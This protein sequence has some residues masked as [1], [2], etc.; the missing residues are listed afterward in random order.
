[1]NPA[2]RPRQILVVDD[3]E[4]TLYVTCRL[5]EGKGYHVFPAGSVRSASDVARHIFFDLLIAD[6]QLPDGSGLDLLAQIRGTYPIT[7]IVV[8]GH[9]RSADVERA[10][11]A[12]FAHHFVKPVDLDQMFS[13]IDRLL[14]DPSKTAEA[15]FEQSQG[16]WCESTFHDM[17]A[18]LGPKDR[19]HLLKFLTHRTDLPA[20]RM[21]QIIMGTQ[22]P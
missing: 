7:G 9:G 14:D 16:Q 22:L 4:D 8:S 20:E 1:M 12:G 6:V 13:T 17:L 5:L 10:I 2:S 19:N 18:N 11:T 3:H 15:R 21:R